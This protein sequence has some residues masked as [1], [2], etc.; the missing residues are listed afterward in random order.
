M[1]GSANKAE[2][3][4][5]AQIYSAGYPSAFLNEALLEEYWRTVAHKITIGEAPTLFDRAKR[6][7]KRGEEYVIASAAFLSVIADRLVKDRHLREKRAELLALPGRVELPLTGRTETA[8]QAER[9]VHRIWAQLS[10]DPGHG[11]ADAIADV[12]GNAPAP[13]VDPAWKGGLAGYW[14]AHGHAPAPY[15]CKCITAV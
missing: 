2:F 15:P 14:N 7:S 11:C 10:A 8:R 3:L 6:E 5:M 1:I 4:S 13:V 9:E 12:V